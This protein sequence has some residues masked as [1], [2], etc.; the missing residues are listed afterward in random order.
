LLADQG[1]AAALGA[2]ARRSPIPVEVQVN[3][4][5]RYAPGIEAAVYFS[6]LECL[7][8]VSKYAGAS[9]ATVRVTEEAGTVAFEVSDDGRGFDVSSNGS[10]SGLRGIADRLGALD[11]AIE[12]HSAPGRGTRISGKVPLVVGSDEIVAHG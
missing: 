8:N 2:Q 7:Q 5:S 12:V 4:P 1:L 6:C 11:G 3:L 10:G 9:G